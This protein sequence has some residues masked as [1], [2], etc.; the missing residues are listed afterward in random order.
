MGYYSG[1]GAVS[2]GG[3]VVSLR[4]NGPD[5]AGPYTTYQRTTSTVTAKHGVSLAAAQA[6][7]GNI[8]LTYWQWPGGVIE[9]ACKGTKTNAA[10][11]QIANSNLYDLSVTNET[12]Q[13][14]GVQGSYDS[15]W[16]S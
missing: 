1:P 3:S 16:V 12:I 13:V 15:G 11:T 7:E 14:R 4:S 9:P 8:N 2:N 6:S 5:V 10:Y